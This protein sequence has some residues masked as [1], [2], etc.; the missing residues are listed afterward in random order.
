MKV[1]DVMQTKVIAVRLDTKGVSHHT[2]A[3]VI[4]EG[5]VFVEPEDSISRAAMLLLQRDI[6]SIPVMRDGKLVGIISRV[7]SVRLLAKAE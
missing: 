1:Q 5:V 6:R 2:A 3:D 4:I 7:D